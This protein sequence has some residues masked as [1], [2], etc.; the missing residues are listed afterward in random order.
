MQAGPKLQS[1]DH[2]IGAEVSQA[3]KIATIESGKLICNAETA[4]TGSGKYL[5]TKLAT[6][7]KLSNQGCVDVGPIPK[8][9]SR[10]RSLINPKPKERNTRAPECPSSYFCSVRRFLC[11]ELL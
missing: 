8:G 10:R 5:R 1:N 2:S 9:Q 7:P 4:T 6:I 11:T 3:T